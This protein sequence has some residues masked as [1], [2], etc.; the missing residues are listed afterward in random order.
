MKTF[1]TALIALA[2]AAAATTSSFATD[3][4]SGRGDREVQS[5]SY[6]TDSYVSGRDAVAPSHGNSSARAWFGQG[7]IDAPLIRE[8]NDEASAPS[9]R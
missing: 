5:Q 3:N 4:T 7:T 1:S 9:G 8:R 2:V 6:T